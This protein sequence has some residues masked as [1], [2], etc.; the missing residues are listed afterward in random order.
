MT[1]DLN[2]ESVTSLSDKNGSSTGQSSV[3]LIMSVMLVTMLS[4]GEVD[5]DQDAL[6][7]GDKDGKGGGEGG[8]PGSNRLI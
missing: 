5:R 8:T 7:D 2:S 4:V 6:V 1:A 3:F